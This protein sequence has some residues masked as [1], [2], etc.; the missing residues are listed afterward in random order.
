MSANPHVA[1]AL[2]QKC[3]PAVPLPNW[4][5]P[6]TALIGEHPAAPLSKCADAGVPPHDAWVSAGTDVVIKPV[7]HDPEGVVDVLPAP[8]VAVTTTVSA[9]PTSDAPTVYVLDVAPTPVASAH[10]PVVGNVI[11]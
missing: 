3:S 9:F 1:G 2:V 11:A 4:D 8:L 6:T 10:E 5:G 7:S